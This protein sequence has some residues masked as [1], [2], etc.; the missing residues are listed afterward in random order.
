MTIV[1]SDTSPIRALDF[2]DLLEVL[3]VLFD[4]V[5]IPPAVAAELVR[6]GGRFRLIDVNEYAFL[7]IHAAHDQSQVDRLLPLL[8]RGEAEAIVLAQ[9][10]AAEAILIDEAD[11]RRVAQETYGLRT[12][13]TLG[14][15]LS[16]KQRG[17]VS[18]VRPLVDQL[19]DGLGFFISERLRQEVLR[20]AKELG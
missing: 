4:R 11:G 15:L 18:A 13:G 19:Q 6:T 2:L 20:L 9:E 16:A 17:E 10:V 7:R 5:L 3:P 14:I 8:D 1:V 12:I